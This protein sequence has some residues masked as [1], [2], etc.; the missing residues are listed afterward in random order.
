MK[1]RLLSILLVAAMTATMLIGCGSKE[2]SGD[3]AKKDEE[4]GGDSITL[5]APD[6]AIPTED[7]LAAFTKETGIEVVVNEV[8][9]DDIREKLATAASGGQAAADVVEVDWSWVG[10]FHA[11][12]WLETL[13]VTE[14]DKKDMPT[15][16]TFTKEGKVLAIPYAN[17]YRL[18]YYNTKQFEKAGIKEEPQTWDDVLEACRALK[19]TG[20]VE[21]PF[22]IALNAEEKTSTCLM[23]LA[24]AMNGVVWNEDGTLNKESVTEALQYMETLIKEELVAPE[25][26]TSSGMDA[27]KRITGGSASFLTGPT[28]FVSRSTNEEECGVIGEITPILMPGKE[29]K[30]KV[31]MA[32]PEGLGVT[33]FSENK[34]AAKKFV[35]WY[36]SADMQKELNASNSAIPTRNS[37]LKG[38]VD[39]GSIKNAGAMLE[40]AELIV[41][42][43]PN[44]IPAY[45]AEM[46]NAMYNAINKMALGELTAE[47]AFAE[48]DTKIKELVEQE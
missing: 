16:E 31:T 33:K 39:D 12:D 11:A 44:G 13:D 8:G 1:K 25:D 46:S 7:Q 35:E 32:L 40:E 17:D 28:S 41:S 21:Y 4:K 30:S 45:Y 18:S 9:W 38:L 43:F 19:S 2:K 37:V 20:T 47:K 14:E 23:W 42:P 15:L 6:W 24:Y 27:Y 34:E 36:T 5:M 29:G 10:E 22:A 3:D 26:K 48:M